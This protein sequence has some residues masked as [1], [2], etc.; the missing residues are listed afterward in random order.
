MMMMMM[1]HLAMAMA[2]VSF[3]EH[4]IYFNDN[5]LLSYLCRSLASGVFS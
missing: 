1:M 3:L 4:S 5:H 2:E